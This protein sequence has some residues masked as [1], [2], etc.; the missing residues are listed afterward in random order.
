MNLPLQVK[1]GT[2]VNPKSNAKQYQVRKQL[3]D[4]K[5]K[6][7]QDHDQNKIDRIEAKIENARKRLEEKKKIKSNNAKNVVKSRSVAQPQK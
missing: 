3:L 7:K 6:E 2:N 5:R 4:K 1:P